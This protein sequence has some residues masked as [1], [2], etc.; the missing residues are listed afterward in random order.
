MFVAR[1]QI[2]PTRQVEL[3]L[4]R[5]VTMWDCRCLYGYAKCFWSLSCESLLNKV[6][7]SLYPLSLDPFATKTVFFLLCRPDI[8]V[9]NYPI[10]DVWV[11]EYFWS[12]LFSWF[13]CLPLSC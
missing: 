7:S 5:A 9:K 13:I 3:G 11:Y 8:F 1:M 4:K 6:S 12:V 10:I 2:L